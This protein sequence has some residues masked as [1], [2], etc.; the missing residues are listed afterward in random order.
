MILYFNILC[1]LFSILNLNHIL[2]L[3]IRVFIKNLKYLF[4][5]KVNMNF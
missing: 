1:S 2:N 4:Q 5:V 3:L